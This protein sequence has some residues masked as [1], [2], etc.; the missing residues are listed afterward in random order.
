MSKSETIIVRVTD[1]MRKALQ[2]AADIE[3]VTI[4]EIMRR[5]IDKLPRLGVI[6]D[7]LVEWYDN[8]KE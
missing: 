4:S 8:N 5:L 2:D 3:N 1:E 6:K 7:G